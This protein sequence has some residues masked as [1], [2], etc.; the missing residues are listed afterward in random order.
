MFGFDA[1]AWFILGFVVVAAYVPLHL[2]RKMT[3]RRDGVE[4][5][6]SLPIVVGSPAW[7]LVHC[8]VSHVL[9]SPMPPPHP[10]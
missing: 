6:G 5:L 8:V 4:P 9:I 1:T 2:W 3:D 10:P 7:M